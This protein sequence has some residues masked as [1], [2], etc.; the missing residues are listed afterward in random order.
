VVLASCGTADYGI[1]QRYPVS[2]TVTY[3]GQPLEKGMISFTPDGTKGVGATG[4]IEDGSYALST[5]GGGDGALA[6]C[7][8]STRSPSRRRRTPTTSPGRI[9]SRIPRER[10]QT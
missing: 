8:A 2:G 5:A 10:E 1:G 4:V 9:S 3:N 7:R 6:R